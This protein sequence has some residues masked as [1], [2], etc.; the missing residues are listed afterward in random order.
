LAA[1]LVNQVLLEGRSLTLALDGIRAAHR[2]LDSRELAAAQDLSYRVMRGYGRLHFFLAALAGRPLVP[3]ELAGL[4]LVALAELEGGETPA[5]AAVNEAVSL[6]GRRFPRARGFVNAL[7]RG[8]LRRREELAAAAALDPV[9]RWSFPAWWIERLQAAWPGQWQ[10]ILAAQNAHPPMSLRVN[11]RRLA[12]PAYQA[13]LAEAGI[14]ARQAGEAG[15]ILD[16][17][18]PVGEL[19]GFREG[20]V[21][22]QDLGAQLAAPLLEVA[23]GMRV[24]DACAAPGGKTAH[25][26]EM[27]DLDLLALDVDERRLGRVADNLG[28]LG[29]SAR[30]ATGDAGEPVAWWDGRPFDRILLDAPCTASGVVRRHPD[31]KWLKRPADAT[32]LAEQ[33]ARLLEAVWPLLKQGGKLLYAT[34][35]VFPEENAHQVEA[36]LRRHADAHRDSIALPGGDEG[37]LLPDRDHD[38]FFYARIV[39]A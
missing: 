25:L 31:G 16:K 1:E 26:L 18:M 30:L 8:Y 27:A 14:P 19:P 34:C 20:Q 9:A 2:D 23:D 12:L 35:S 10:A 28:R 21:S 36:F 37:Q 33:Q 38:G 11:R 5:Y 22:V 13:R 7:L 32:G 24:L 39:K 4:V 3:P 6:A 17:P 29:L 15:L